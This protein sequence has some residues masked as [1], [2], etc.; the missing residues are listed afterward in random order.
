MSN[1]TD[2]EKLARLPKWAQERI[3]LLERDLSREREKAQ[4]HLSQEPTRIGLGYHTAQDKM[5]E[6][7]VWLPDDEHVTFFLEDRQRPGDRS[8]SFS[9]DRHSGGVQVRSTDGPLQIE[10]QASNVAVL[11]VSER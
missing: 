9:F 6:P 7:R 2:P 10:P 4:R 3:Q 5:G 8:I 11:N 1:Y